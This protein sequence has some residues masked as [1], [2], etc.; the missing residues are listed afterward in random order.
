VFEEATT[1]R[2]S[3]DKTWYK[4]ILVVVSTQT[5]FIGVFE[6]AK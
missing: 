5:T 4:I 2:S 3:Q 1:E 6:L